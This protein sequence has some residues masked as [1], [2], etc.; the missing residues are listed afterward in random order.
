MGEVVERLRLARSKLEFGWTQTAPAR[1]ASGN[2]TPTDDAG[3]VCWCVFGAV[4]VVSDYRTWENAWKC[5]ERAACEA[6]FYGDHG[7]G[8]GP[9][10]F[11]DAPGRTQ[12]EVLE[13]IDRAIALAEADE[14][15]P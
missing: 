1:D 5:V 8:N 12:A 9:V 4:H 2:V 14:A 10:R 7:T 3:A 11:N 13:L 15:A 6:G